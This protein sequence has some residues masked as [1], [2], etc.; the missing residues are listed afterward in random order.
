MPH[1]FGVPKYGREP[2]TM[3]GN[4]FYNIEVIKQTPAPS[5]T[6]K[7][8]ITSK[9]SNE[10]VRKSSNRNRASS[11]SLLHTV[12]SD[13]ATLHREVDTCNI[14]GM[15]L[16][17]IQS[18]KNES[19]RVDFVKRYDAE[20][21]PQLEQIISELPLNGA[22]FLMHSLISTSTAILTSSLQKAVENGIGTIDLSLIEITFLST[23]QQLQEILEE[24]RTTSTT[25]SSLRDDIKQN[26]KR[27]NFQKLCMAIL[28]ADKSED[29]YE[30]TTKAKADAKE[31]IQ[32]NTNDRAE[33]M[34][35][36]LTTNSFAQINCFINEFNQVNELTNLRTFIS[37]EIPKEDRFSDSFTTALTLMFSLVE[38]RVKEKSDRLIRALTVLKGYI[39]N[40]NPGLNIIRSMQLIN[41]MFVLETHH[42]SKISIEV[43]E[44]HGSTL[45][46]I[47][48][49]NIQDKQY[50]KMLLLIVSLRYW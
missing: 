10:F 46:N 2:P 15:A 39:P 32:A 40:P 24:Y 6:K 25:G 18:C 45:K 34:I 42:M 4:P 31:V 35:K 5:I 29:T 48:S 36:I 41:R 47:L 13:T 50:R 44:K 11:N 26:V 7:E 16:A 22:G 20:F 3:W 30:D 38:N 1:R 19:E 28:D 37:K 9:L 21:S 17:K 14:F 43:E 8:S 27:P 23:S 12:L 49:E 33:K